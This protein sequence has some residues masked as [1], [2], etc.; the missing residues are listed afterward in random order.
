M[1]NLAVAYKS[2]YRARETV[3]QVILGILLSAIAAVMILPMVYVVAV[4]FTDATIYVPNQLTFWPSKW[5]LD[6]YRYILA[7]PGFT[8]ALK[9]SLFLTIVGTPLNLMVTA[10]FAYALSKP[11]LPG[12]R[13]L[14]ALVLFTM[15]FSAGLIPGYLLVRGL[16]LLDTWWAIILPGIADAWSLLVFKSFFQSIPRELEDAARIDGCN[17]LVIFWRI[18]LP[19]SKAPLATF[20]LFFA[21]GYWN[22]YFSAI[23]YIK[24]ATMWPLQVMLQQVVLTAAASRFLS[25]E[26]VA[27]LQLMQ[28]LPQETVKMATVV[29]VTAP[30]LLVYPFLQGYFAKGVLLG[31]IKS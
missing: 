9:A 1:N 27:Q 4:S 28:A 8:N 10:G 6:A 12:R 17:D 21:V 14:L 25:S 31:S 26:A 20:G 30:I 24:D 22:T 19:L 2:R 7:G 29:I 11:E 23:I 13:V 18:V 3:F 15:L 5:S 16:G